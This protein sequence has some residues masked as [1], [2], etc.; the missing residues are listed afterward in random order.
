M[1]EDLFKLGQIFSQMR[2]QSFSQDS[3]KVLFSG[4]IKLVNK[5]F[6]AVDIISLTN[7]FDF[8]EVEVGRADHFEV[9]TYEKSHKI[10]AL[11]YLF[12]CKKIK[13][14]SQS[15]FIRVSHILFRVI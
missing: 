3:R 7:R 4:L 15:C 14:I 1:N 12:I 10:F 13:P 9:R 5:F 6:A 2:Y 8:L 11:I